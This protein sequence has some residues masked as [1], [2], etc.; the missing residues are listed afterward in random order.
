MPDKNTKSPDEIR[1]LVAFK[2]ADNESKI[3]KFNFFVKFF[4]DLKI[5]CQIFF[6]FFFVTLFWRKKIFCKLF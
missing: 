3:L 6:R 5:F 2:V 4:F 1:G